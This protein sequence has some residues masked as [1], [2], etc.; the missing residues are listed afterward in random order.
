M[1][2][3]DA[4]EILEANFAPWVLALDLTVTEIDADHALIRMPLADHLDLAFEGVSGARHEGTLRPS[5]VRRGAEGT[6]I[7]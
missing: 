5:C 7:P 6:I 4:Q 1:T 2:P 3:A